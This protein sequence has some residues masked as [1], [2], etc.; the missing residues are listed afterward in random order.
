MSLN[1][2]KD[3]AIDFGVSDSH[4]VSSLVSKKVRETCL[5]AT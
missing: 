2:N 4:S 5:K 3:E 1:M